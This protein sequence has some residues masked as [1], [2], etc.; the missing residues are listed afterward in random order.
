MLCPLYVRTIGSESE[1]NLERRHRCSSSFSAV[2]GR[3]TSGRRPGDARGDLG[4]LS[5]IEFWKTN[6]CERRYLDLNVGLMYD[7]RY[8]TTACRDVTICSESE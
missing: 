2:R 8:C 3:S 1:E 4:E 6:Y 7:H 5:F